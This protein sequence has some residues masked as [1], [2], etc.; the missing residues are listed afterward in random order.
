MDIQK[1]RGSVAHRLT[2]RMQA[3]QGISNTIASNDAM[4]EIIIASS[5]NCL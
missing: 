2:G 3:K 5:R 4:A 1:T